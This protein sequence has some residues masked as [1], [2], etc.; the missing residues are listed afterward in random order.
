MK[1]CDNTS[2]GALILDDHGRLLAF[3]RNT[4]PPGVAG[5]A[6][7]V[8]EHGGYV[9][10]IYAEVFEEVGLTV[11][12]AEL[13][14]GGWRAGPC[15][16]SPGPRGN[17]HQWQV[18]LVGALGELVP[19]ERETRNARWLD[20]QALQM[21]TDRTLSYAG[22]VITTEEFRAEPGIEPVW[23]QWLHVADLVEVTPEQLDLVADLSYRAPWMLLDED[24]HA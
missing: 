2:V 19:S 13:I 24:G 11:V 17:G 1:T 10:A 3:D 20:R 7:H 9:E 23:V 21:L 14:T 8:D 5:P 22:G 12:S 18:F 6:G 16:R 15:R 4:D